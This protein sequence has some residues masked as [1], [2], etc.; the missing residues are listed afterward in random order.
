[1]SAW[2]SIRIKC[3]RG[4]TCLPDSVCR[5]VAPLWHFILILNQ[6]DMLLHSDTLFWYWIRQTCCSTLTLYSDTESSRHVAPLWHFIL[7][8][9]SRV[10]SNV[11]DHEFE[12]LSSQTK[13]YIIGICCFSANHTVLRSKSTDWD[14]NK[15]APLWN[16]ILI[17]NQVDMLL[18]SDTLFWYWIRQTCCST[19]TLYSDTESGIQYQNKVSE[20]SNMSAWFSIRIKCQCGATC[21]PDSVSE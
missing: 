2:F 5:H 21:L 16:F 19:L 9:V 18:H 8:A 20:W 15:V 3:Q 6:A 10:S 11:V 17:L 13:D 7:V 4:A 14:Q 12:P 1:M